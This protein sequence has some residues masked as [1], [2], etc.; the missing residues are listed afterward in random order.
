MECPLC[1]GEIAEGA[2]VCKHCKSKIIKCPNCL[3]FTDGNKDLCQVCGSVIN[4]TLPQESL[5]EAKILLMKKKKS[6]VLALLLN[7]LWAGWGIYYC[8][9]E[10]G[11]WIAGANIVAFIIS[12][13]TAGIPCLILFVYA[14]IICY[15]H[16]EI[17]NTQLEIDIA[18]KSIH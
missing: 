12:I 9:A 15:K 16:I 2:L 18:K 13:F 7:F 14:S 6:F 1:K 10:E 3:E 17:Y 11:K 5:D 8:E 4:K